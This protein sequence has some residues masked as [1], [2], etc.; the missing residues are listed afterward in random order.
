M[1]KLNCGENLSEIEEERYGPLYHLLYTMV[2]EDKIICPKADQ[3]EEIELGE[4]LI[5][6]CHDLQVSLSLGI[7]FRYR[8]GIEDMQRQ[9]IMKAYIN[10]EEYIE[11]DYKDAFYK[12]PVA[13]LLSHKPFIIS[14]S[15][16]PK[17]DQ[18]DK[19]KATKSETLEQLKE[20]KKSILG[21][22][23]TYKQQLQEE[24]TAKVQAGTAALE[25]WI[26]KTKKGITPSEDD[27]FQLQIIS[28]PLTEWK[29][30]NGQPEGFEGLYRFLLSEEYKNMPYVDI[31][32]KL[33]AKVV[34]GG[35]EIQS[36]DSMDI[37]QLSAVLP[38]CNYV[39]TDR[40]M[41][42]RLIDLGLD[43]K[44]NTQVCYIGDFAYIMDELSK[45]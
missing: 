36:G 37:D 4:R 28:L 15:P 8:L 31:S 42:N 34:T 14:V 23:I 44:Y 19:R 1:T 9:L 7:N 32:S 25:N 39:I 10:K 20:L 17:K 5:K 26:H 43:R 12:D 33:W 21:Q 38:Y 3:E 29:H 11:L 35:S 22:G 16:N 13:E 40:K 24:Y 27:F 2:R 18:I 6:E 30:Y 45:L 41:K